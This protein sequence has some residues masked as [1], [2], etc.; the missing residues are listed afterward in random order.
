MVN[1]GWKNW[2]IVLSFKSRAH[3]G[4]THT[5]FSFL[6]GRLDAAGSKKTI[7]EFPVSVISDQVTVV[8]KDEYF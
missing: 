6:K 7:I 2:S 4:E 5:L 8:E 3:V 1:V